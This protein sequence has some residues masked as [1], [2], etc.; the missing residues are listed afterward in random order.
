MAD[1]E[2]KLPATRCIA[3]VSQTLGPVLP[4]SNYSVGCFVCTSKVDWRECDRT[5]KND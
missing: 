5:V 4:S 3:N 2:V 1:F